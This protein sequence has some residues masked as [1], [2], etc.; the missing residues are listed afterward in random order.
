MKISRLMFVVINLIGI[1]F[2]FVFP[3]FLPGT[4]AYF[5]PL[6]SWPV[7]C[8]CIWGG[9][10]GRIQYEDDDN[11]VWRLDVETEPL[12]YWWAMGMT[13]SAGWLLMLAMRTDK[14][15]LG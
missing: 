13:S 7:F 4:K 15:M 2:P 11:R 5:G 14:T 12:T 9:W 6:W 3:H 10:R 8:F 1:V